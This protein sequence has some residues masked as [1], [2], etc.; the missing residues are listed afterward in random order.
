[1]RIDELR[2]PKASPSGLETPFGGVPAAKQ[3]SGQRAEGGLQL[4]EAVAQ[5]H[6]LLPPGTRSLHLGQAGAGVLQRLAQRHNVALQSP[7]GGPTAAPPQ[8]GGGECN[9]TPQKVQCKKNAKK[10]KKVQIPKKFPY[11]SSFC[12]K[13]K[14]S[15]AFD[16]GMKM[17]KKETSQ[18]LAYPFLRRSCIKMQKS[19]K[20]CNL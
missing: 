12:I 19:A 3:G 13:K 8:R 17:S 2:K 15:S 16:A 14:A 1:M 9:L 7:E 11:K 6:H 10:C 18:P 4:S 20:K 5:L